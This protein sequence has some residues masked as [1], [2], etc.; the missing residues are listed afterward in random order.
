MEEGLDTVWAEET[1][2]V[3]ILRQNHGKLEKQKEGL[4]LGWGRDSGVAKLD[5]G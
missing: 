5:R 2:C 3:E 4:W 1:A